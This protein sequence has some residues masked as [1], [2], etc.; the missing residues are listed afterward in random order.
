MQL[1]F[2]QLVNGVAL[3][4]AYALFAMGFGLVLATMGILNVAHGTYATFGA[5]AALYAVDHWHVPF[6]VGLLVTVAFSA[7]LAVVVDQVA[8][9]PLRKRGGGV[10]GPIITSIGAWIILGELALIATDAQ[11][12]NYPPRWFSS[13]QFEWAGITLPAS[14]LLTVA[15]AGAIVAAMFLFLQRT[16]AGAAVRAVGFSAPSAAIGGVNPRLVI[17]GTAALSGAVA[18]L[19]GTVVALYTDNVS[20]A[21]GEGLLLKGFA[22]VVVGGFGDVRGTFLGGLLIGVSEVMGA[23]YISNSFRDAITFGL[24]LLFLLLRPQGIFG[25]LKFGAAR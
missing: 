5:L 18:G 1:F 9:Q 6:V 4:S 15:L 22:A 12:K 19:A 7:T 20:F 23:Q 21:L 13:H 25:E 24:L 17:V 16:S 8:F 11:P 3:G 2:Q 10:L 14:Q